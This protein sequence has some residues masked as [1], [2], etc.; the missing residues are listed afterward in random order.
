MQ[1][2]FVLFAVSTAAIS[3]A[4]YADCYIP[5]RGN[6]EK[7]ALTIVATACRALDPTK[8]EKILADKGQISGDRAAFMERNYRGALVTVEQS[9]YVYPSKDADAC[10]HFPIGKPV[11]MMIDQT[12]CDT[13]AW[14]KC[15][16]GGRFL[17][18]VGTQPFN[19]FQ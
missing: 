6:T 13:G 12:C 16:Y 3:A 18:D 9:T 14:G 19:A 15:I 11:K 10:S 5:E 7:D 4:A 8:D 1:N 2:G 17:R